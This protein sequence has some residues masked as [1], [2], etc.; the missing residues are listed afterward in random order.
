MVSGLG[1]ASSRSNE[2]KANISINNALVGALMAPAGVTFT[3]SVP[4]TNP[5]GLVAFAGGSSFDLSNLNQTGGYGL[6]ANHPSGF[7]VYAGTPN[8]FSAIYATSIIG[9]GAYGS[10]QHSYGMYARNVNMDHAGLG[11]TGNPGAIFLGGGPSFGD[12]TGSLPAN[13][14]V[15]TIANSGYPLSLANF[16]DNQSVGLYAVAGQG[17]GT[18]FGN[19]PTY[20]AVLAGN[21]AVYGSLSKGGGSFKID[22]PLDPKNK[23]LYHSFVE[24]PDMLNLYQGIATLDEQGEG[25]VEL[26]E[27]FCTLNRDFRYQLTPLGPNAGLF[28]A[29]EMEGNRFK[30]GG[31]LGGM[32]VSWQISGIRQDV[33]ANA[34]RIPVEEEKR[35]EEKGRYLHAE[36]Y[37][38]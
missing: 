12:V 10:S 15:G 34:N 5:T 13:C 28:V 35:P 31:G 1:A 22:H 18:P 14:I 27:W 4:D 8:G 21:V 25:W 9:I 20:A 16:S 2:A 6:Y 32:R 33:W 24:S 30:I 19:I 17:T 38:G 11:G 37:P 29:K 36:L 3:G 26:P 23:Y 7:G